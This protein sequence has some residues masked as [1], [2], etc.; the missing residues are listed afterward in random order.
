MVRRGRPAGR[1]YVTSPV[2]ATGWSPSSAKTQHVTSPVGATGWSPSSVETQHED[3][4]MPSRLLKFLQTF[5][6]HGQI[7]PAL[8]RAYPNLPNCLLKRHSALLS[9]SLAG[10]R[11]G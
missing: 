1:P 2:G 8:K 3:T 11:H 9:M 6:R 4:A 5:R 7:D 10:N